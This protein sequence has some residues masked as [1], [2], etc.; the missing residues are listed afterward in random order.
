LAWERPIGSD[1]YSLKHLRQGSASIEI[2]TDLGLSGI[3]QVDVT[4]IKPRHHKR[5][6]QVDQPGARLLEP[7]NCGI[8]AGGYN[9]VAADRDGRDPLRRG[10]KADPS[11]NVTVVIN[12]LYAGRG[13]KQRRRSEQPANG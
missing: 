5:A 6:L 8:V 11:N 4:I 7:Q 12:S 1:A 10:W 2:H 9:L 3:R 13:R